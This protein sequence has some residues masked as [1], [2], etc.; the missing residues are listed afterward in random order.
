MSFSLTKWDLPCWHGFYAKLRLRN[1]V[2]SRALGQ[3]RHWSQWNSS[4]CEADIQVGNLGFIP[5]AKLLFI[6]FKLRNV[7][8]RQDVSWSAQDEISYNFMSEV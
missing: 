2:C 6:L 7:K 8:V 3:S 5:M 1:L 4:Y